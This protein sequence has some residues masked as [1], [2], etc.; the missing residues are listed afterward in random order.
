MADLDLASL[1]DEE[2]G[3][4]RAAVNAEYDRRQALAAI[5]AR[6]EAANLEYLAAEGVTDGLPWRAP[7]GAHDAY[8]LGWTVEHD[9][10]AW[11]SLT[12]FNPW[13]PPT[14]WREVAEEGAHP[15]W[16]QPT[17]AH[18]AYPLDAIVS[19]GG[20]TWRS[21]ANANVWEPGVYGWVRVD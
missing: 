4:L 17:G 15:A 7:T 18:D 10:K 12:A 11:V 14:G 8:P 6:L 5:P 20:Y 21:T 3:H 1:T 16:V 9:G 19:H 2:V 13:E